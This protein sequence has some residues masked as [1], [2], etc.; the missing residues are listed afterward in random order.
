MP[1]ELVFPPNLVA[2]YRKLDQVSLPATAIQVNKEALRSWSQEE[3]LIYFAPPLI[4]PPAFLAISGQVFDLLAGG[5][6]AMAKEF[7]ALKASLPTSPPRQQGLVEALLKRDPRAPAFLEPQWQ[8]EP[9]FFAFAFSHVL[10]LFLGAYARLVQAEVT[11]EKWGKGECPVC[12]S[13]PN[14]GRID[15]D[16]KRYLFCSLCGSEWR[17]VRVCCPF[18]GN[19]VPDKLGFYSSEENCYRLDV[20]EACKGYLK[21]LDERRRAEHESLFWEDIKTVPLDV[22]AMRLGF[23]NRAFS[24]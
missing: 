21:T 16:G 12:A 5:L 8:V 18:C 1:K 9:D 13:R 2:C 4:N 14:F 6:P 10:R 22:M 15:G 3:A 19:S 11:F 23:V 24:L 20:C 7:G 17:F